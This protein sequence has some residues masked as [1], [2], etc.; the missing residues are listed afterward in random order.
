MN[1]NAIWD[2]FDFIAVVSFT[3][4]A[5][6]R[7]KDLEVSLERAGLLPRTQF[8]WGFPTPYMAKAHA[9]LRTRHIATPGLLDCTF[10]HYRI[11]K[12]AYELGAS[13]VLVMEDD[14]RFASDLSLLSA[15]VDSLPADFDIAKFEWFFGRAET[16]AQRRSLAPA[17]GS[18]WAPMYG[19]R[20]VG[21]ACTAF[22]RRGL[23]WRI[24][25]LESGVDGVL[26]CCDMYYRPGFL[27]KDLNALVSTPLV[28]VQGDMKESMNA[29]S[30][31]YDDRYRLP[32][33]YN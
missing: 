25:T 21:D 17:P 2:R 3:G 18:L 22:S 16:P 5:K 15:A 33:G 10:C 19:H 24:R 6:T 23:E 1:S 9:A 26:R 8:F 31:A 4:H 27:G 30:K 20:I 29:L 32:C 14:V 28:A 11:A 12:T 13:S 7:H